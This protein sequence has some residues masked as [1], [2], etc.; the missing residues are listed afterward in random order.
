MAAAARAV[1]FRS[2]TL[3]RFLPTSLLLLSPSRSRNWRLVTLWLLL[4]FVLRSLLAAFVPLLPDETYYWEWTRRLAGGY[5]DHPP[6][7]AL[8][9]RLG[10]LL[11]GDTRTG[12][13]AGPAIAALITHAAAVLLAWNLAGRGSAGETAARRGAILLTLVP[14]ATL[15]LVLATPDAALFMT[16]MLA[17]VSVERALASPLQSRQS[18]AWWTAAGVALGGAFASKYTAVLLPAGLVVAC[19]VHPALRAR[20][21]EPGPW[22]ASL[23]G[24][25]LFS[26]VVLWNRGHHWISFRFQLGHGFTP[27]ARGNPLSR[28]LEL[29]GAQM[30]L[31]SP[32]L[33]VLMAMVV[34]LAVRE[35]W[36]ARSTARPVDES[37]R[38][39]AIAV[40]SVV[41]LAFFA[42][43]AW[44]RSVEANWPALIYPGAIAL[45]ATSTYEWA[46][47]RSWRVGLGV[48]AFL[49]AVVTAQAWR[50]VLPLA[51]RKDPIARAHGWT[52]LAASVDSARNAAFLSGADHRW[53]AADRYQ[54]ASELAFHLPGQPNV[55][56]LNLGGRANQYDLWPTVYESLKP[57]DGMVAAFDANEGGDALALRVSAWFESTEKGPV[58]SLMRGAGEVTQRRIWLYRNAR[59]VPAALV[60]GQAN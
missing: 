56:S 50:P 45:L 39:F 51:P 14:I 47:R 54:D 13:R 8:L 32:V 35:G 25:L 55:F 9:A 27:S 38:R 18:L 20:F 31:A 17:L 42:V 23:V 6:G 28:E 7:I 58:V 40:I 2:S 48:A 49:L 43:S 21:R 41:P 11:A 46:H 36:R 1:Y 26:P 5:F 60:K 59:G 24:L 16:T 3:L 4:A 37:T 22:I 15:G 10:T 53:V 19:L 33:F 34:V 52:T 12:V 57:G 44:R 30:G 29:V